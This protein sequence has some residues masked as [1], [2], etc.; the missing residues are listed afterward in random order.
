[1]KIRIS[2]YEWQ[3]KRSGRDP[4]YVLSRDYGKEFKEE[5]KLCLFESHYFV[6]EKLDKE[7]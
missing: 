2:I 7:T 6:Y 5:I 1:M 4:C 3:E